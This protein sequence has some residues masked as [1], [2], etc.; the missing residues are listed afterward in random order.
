MTYI[1][2]YVFSS[3]IYKKATESKLVEMQRIP[4][5]DGKQRCI[6][7]EIIG[8]INLFFSNGQEHN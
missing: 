8:S 5:Q 6:Q 4:N 7:G 3:V 1:S 2:I